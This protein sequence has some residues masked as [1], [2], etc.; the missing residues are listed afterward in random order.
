M[1]M[2]H[3]FVLAAIASACLGASAEAGTLTVAAP[4]AKVCQLTG[5]T[6][7]AGNQPTAAQT[8]ANFGLDSVDLGFPVES[9]PG[10][11]YFLFGDA[12]P[13]T[14][15]FSSVPPDDAFGWTTRTA[16]PDANSCLD[17]QLATSAPKTFAHPRVTPAIQQG[18]FN[19]PSGGIFL[20]GTI[21]AF[22]WTNHCV[23]P[24]T[25][26]PNPGAPLQYP[27]PTATC[28]QI[29]ANNSVG[30]SVL[31]SASPS[32]PIAFHRC[33][34]PATLVV[35]CPTMPRGFVYVSAA[36]PPRAIGR[37]ILLRPE[38]IPVF[39]VPR[40]R[41][42]IPYLAM[43]P[44]ATFA[45]PE[46]WSFFAGRNAGGNPIWV[47]RAQWE[48]GQNAFGQWIPPA[49]AEIY[50]ATPGQRCVGEHQVTWNAALRTWLLLYN[51]QPWTVE[52]RTAP[53]PW[54]PWSQPTVLLHATPTSPLVCTLIMSVNGCPGLRN[55]WP[56]G[57]PPG[58]FYA[59]FAL[60]RYTRDT[61]VAGG[62]TR[63][64][65]IYW[66]LSTWNPYQVSIMQTDL[67][68]TP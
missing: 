67:Q 32:D 24:G 5:Q 11:L 30:S 47:T 23:L 52:A 8:V 66:T 7:W 22:F 9:D 61:T 55:Y 39:G 21:Y 25:L 34:G 44:R 10:P 27:A 26:L 51:C 46:T 40:Y 36:I 28:A 15:T 38:S 13:L 16:A 33:G 50:G 41:A 59:P 18:S 48:S 29:P 14:H 19:V 53:D 42:S 12:F 4:S 60:T 54:G 45:D 56:P 20:D 35:R 62:A 57:N 2:S 63:S 58:I 68:F 17:L 65:T 49:G 1:K 43:A 31:A 6:D 3:G 64:A 37:E